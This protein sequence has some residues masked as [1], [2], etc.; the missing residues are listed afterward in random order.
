ML[1]YRKCTEFTLCSPGSIYEFSSKQIGNNE[2][3]W[4]Q[5]EN[6]LNFLSYFNEGKYKELMRAIMNYFKLGSS[7]MEQGSQTH[8]RQILTSIF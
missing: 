1:Q 4:L 7:F 5:K 6:T 2:G 8:F 3:N